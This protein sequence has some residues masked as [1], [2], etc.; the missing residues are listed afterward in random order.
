MCGSSKVLLNLLTVVSMFFFKRTLLKHFP[1]IVGL[2][3]IQKRKMK[4]FEL[5]FLFGILSTHHVTLTLK[6]TEFANYTNEE[7]LHKYPMDHYLSLSNLN[8]S[9]TFKRMI[10]NSTKIEAPED[11]EPESQ[12]STAGDRLNTFTFIVEGLGV[13]STSII[14]NW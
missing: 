5:V 6:D 8:S 1:L 3:C 11:S 14:G 2:I 13:S 7:I 12:Q 10:L 4:L 9:L